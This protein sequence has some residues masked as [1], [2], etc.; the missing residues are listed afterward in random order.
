MTRP[1]PME[2]AEIGRACRTYLPD[3]ALFAASEDGSAGPFTLPSDRT[4]GERVLDELERRGWRI[5]R[6][7]DHG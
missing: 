3:A 6:E 1:S 5:V 7:A 4:I 2:L